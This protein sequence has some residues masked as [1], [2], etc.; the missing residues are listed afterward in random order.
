MSPQGAL[1]SLTFASCIRARSGSSQA[2]L[3]FLWGLVC[4]RPEGASE[5][6]KR[7]KGTFWGFRVLGVGNTKWR[8]VGSAWPRCEA[9]ARLR[10]V[11]K[12]FKRGFA[13]FSAGSKAFHDRT[14]TK[15]DR[16]DAHSMLI[17][18]GYRAKS[19]VSSSRTVQICCK[20]HSARLNC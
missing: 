16:N 1:S 12:H 20:I 13:G 17:I 14:A 10:W 11:S 9:S 8:T 5:A 6:A 18:V 3:C 7:L 4:H 19:L 15:W 2:R